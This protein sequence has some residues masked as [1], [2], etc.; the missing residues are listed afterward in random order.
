MS[1]YLSLINDPET[2]SYVK[3]VF[4]EAVELCS[5]YWEVE[6]DFD[7][8]KNHKV[9]VQSRRKKGFLGM[10]KKQ[11]YRALSFN[12]NAIGGFVSLTAKCDL[13][14]AVYE[15]SEEIGCYDVLNGERVYF[16]Q[17]ND[18]KGNDLN[19][20]LDA[21]MTTKKVPQKSIIFPTAFVDQ[22]VMIRD[23]DN[24]LRKKFRPGSVMFMEDLI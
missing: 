20:L 18:Y 2:L 4:E 10:L 14:S 12:Y 15:T 9:L 24:F 7:F 3:K 19:R 17:E 23:I 1:S 13:S 6:T 21:I 11:E 16:V 5:K 22:A 8:E